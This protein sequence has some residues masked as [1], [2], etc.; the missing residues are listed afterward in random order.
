MGSS[1]AL[2]KT[3]TDRAAI[4]ARL[5]EHEATRAQLLES[6]DLDAIDKLDQEI[7]A[8]RHRLAIID[9][10][11]KVIS[12]NVRRG[13]HNQ[14]EAER[15]AAIKKI[16]AKLEK[17]NALVIELEAGLKNVVALYD[18]INDEKS[19]RAAWPFGVPEHFS[20]GIYDFNRELLRALRDDAGGFH[21]IPAPV[22][23]ILGSKNGTGGYTEVLRPSGP[24]GLVGQFEA[25]AKHILESLQKLNIH[26]PEPVADNETV[27]AA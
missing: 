18:R 11:L 21:V 23:A 8:D 19:L 2:T 27:E 10:R 14:R 16:A 5:T 17:R 25:K 13:Q 26:P 1:E 15:A 9:Q 20:W 22:N 12:R 24:T 6:D 3:Q 4:L 7:S